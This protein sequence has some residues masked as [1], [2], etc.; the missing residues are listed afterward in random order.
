[1]KLS[2][3]VEWAVHCAMLLSA[4]PQGATLSGKAL[5]AF[6]GVPESY[7]LKHLK[8]LVESGVL[9]SLTGPRGGYRLA[10]APERISLL[11]IVRAVDGAKPAFRCTDIRRRGPCGLGDD[12]Y[13]RPCGINRA[14][15]RAEKAYREAL[16]R[17]DLKS[18]AEEFMATADSRILRLGGDWLANNTRVPR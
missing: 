13:P 18:L 17:E 3:G 10:R 9:E 16:A 8:S 15:L 4:L 6:H 1:M 2:D 12:A 11:D 14:M 7:L 5:A